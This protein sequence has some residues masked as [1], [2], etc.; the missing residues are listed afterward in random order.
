M[1]SSETGLPKSPLKGKNQIKVIS[2]D[3]KDEIRNHIKSF[4]VVE[5]HYCRA[6]SRKTYLESNLNLTK[7]YALYVESVERPQKIHVYRKIFDYEF[8]IAF[9]KPKKDV[10]D[11]CAEFR[12]NATPSDEQQLD[13]NAHISRKETC[14]KERDKDRENKDKL[15][16]TLT[17]DLENVFS[18]PKT[19]ISS[20]FY[21]Q[22][23][24]C[25]NLTAHC[26]ANKTVYCSIWHEGFAGRGGVEIANGL[27]RIL[28]KV[29]EE[30]PYLTKIILWSDSCVPQNRN[31]IMSLALQNFLISPHSGKLQTIEQKYSEPGHG[32][33]QEVDS[34]HSVIERHIREININSPLSLLRTLKK[35][36]QGKTK[37]SILQMR[38]TDYLNYEAK[39]SNFKYNLVP[40][41]KV[42]HIIYN[43]ENI[44]KLQYRKDFRDELEN[45]FLIDKRGVELRHSLK[46]KPKFPK[47]MK[48]NVKFEVSESKKQALFSMLSTMEIED[49]EFYK[50]TILHDFKNDKNCKE[51]SANE[52][53]KK[54]DEAGGSTSSKNVV[55][56]LKK[57]TK[58]ATKNLS[59][60]VGGK[61]KIQ[62]NN[63]A[64]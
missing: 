60:I 19:N 44:F 27:V 2:N 41:T 49:Q 6:S 50:Q 22:K 26:S 58:T 4:P 43:K 29:V 45:V 59:N 48:L 62:R 5:S 35:L 61:K 17:F 47:I 53:H 52:C 15:T 46:E 64:V 31:S 40:Y 25:Y 57:G 56:K 37:F 20:H 8:N 14:K 1:K 39:S 12:L 9:H 63:K 54:T 34:V 51:R 32:N 16:A 18:L 7:M 42:K 28:T 30:N 13:Y 23:L 3:A 38:V 24:T 21:K 36:P 11:K 55:K 10:C 33:V